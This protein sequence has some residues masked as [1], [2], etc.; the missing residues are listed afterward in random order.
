M[1]KILVLLTSL[2]LTS[3]LASNVTSC[4]TLD[5]RIKQAF[6]SWTF[7]A[8]TDAPIYGSVFRINKDPNWY[9]YYYWFIQQLLIA[10]QFNLID[11]TMYQL[12]LSGDWKSLDPG[13]I[14]IHNI[15]PT[16]YPRVIDSLERETDP[17]NK[18]DFKL[19]Y[20]YLTIY[21]PII[22]QGGL[23]T[24]TYSKEHSSIKIEY[25]ISTNSAIEAYKSKIKTDYENYYKQIINLYPVLKTYILDLSTANQT[26]NT[27]VDSLIHVE[28][29][30]SPNFNIALN[31]N[32]TINPI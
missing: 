1:K 23:L 17:L 27:L 16:W 25:K 24:N 18:N 29:V 20:T 28:V 6:T 11:K 4:L 2:T 15:A 21:N 13:T 7:N 26:I 22:L 14:S 19:I 3:S 30:L 10:S 9:Y 5:N 8:K 31:I 12:V 32:T